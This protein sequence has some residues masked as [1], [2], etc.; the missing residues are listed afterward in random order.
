M[1]LESM[2]WAKTK[3]PFRN[4]AHVILHDHVHW[5]LLPEP[6][7]IFSDLVAAFKRDVTWRRKDTGRIGP[8]WQKRFYDHIIRDEGDF[9]RHLD[10]V[11]FNPVKHGLV[12]SAGD[13][14]WSSFSEWVK[15]DVYPEDWGAIESDRIKGMDLE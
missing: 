13:H 6:G 2:H 7:V 10:Y 9:A 4:I 1:L 15:R 5:I 11:H 14:R 3:Y 12:R 8:F